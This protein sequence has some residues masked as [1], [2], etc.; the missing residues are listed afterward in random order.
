LTSLTILD[1]VNF[2]GKNSDLEIF[3]EAVNVQNNCDDK[4]VLLKVDRSGSCTEIVLTPSKLRTRPQR[5]PVTVQSL[6]DRMPLLKKE[7][8]ETPT[9]LPTARTK[10]RQLDRSHGG[11][12]MPVLEKEA[13]EDENLAA[14]GPDSSADSGRTS[15]VDKPPIRSR[16]RLVDMADR[17][18]GYDPREWRVPKLTIRR[19]RASGQS[20]SG[21]SAAVI[22]STSPSG[23]I[24][25]ILP[26]CGRGS[27]ES[28]QSSDDSSLSTTAT[29][30]P[31]SIS[32]ACFYGGV[33]TT[34]NALK[35]L[36]LKFGEE[37]VAI[38]VEHN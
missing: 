9:H 17:H 30:T 26:S 12:D 14:C 28:Q 35:R 8:D 27:V 3:V 15:V 33:G 11:D 37:S 2:S 38:D 36:R 19:R 7:S 24:Y 21:N 29:S 5:S 34:G 20:G 22:S 1:S 6:E 23:L 13:E 10:L 4:N 18:F 31:D 32:P 16:W 25:E